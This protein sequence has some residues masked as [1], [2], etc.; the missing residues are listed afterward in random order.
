MT[1]DLELG[2]QG[3]GPGNWDLEPGT[4]DLKLRLATSDLGPDL[5][6]RPGISDLISGTWD[7]ELK[8]LEP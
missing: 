3:L 1:W 6:P 5:E 4:S 2:T 7:Q 8:E